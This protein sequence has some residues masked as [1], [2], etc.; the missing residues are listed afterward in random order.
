MSTN[1]FNSMLLG[2]K[3]LPALEV[4][5]LT[6]CLKLA[7][8]TAL[9]ILK[10]DAEPIASHSRHFPL[11]I[12]SNE[13][14]PPHGLSSQTWKCTDRLRSSRKPWRIDWIPSV[15]RIELICGLAIRS[16]EPAGIGPARGMPTQKEK[17]KFCRLSI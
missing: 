10:L 3:K 5:L 1:P 4:P 11:S 8:H 9:R 16:L 13:G 14:G 6:V 7:V 15:D 17:R 12:Q 2:D